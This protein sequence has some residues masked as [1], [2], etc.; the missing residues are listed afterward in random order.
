MPLLIQTVQGD[1]RLGIQAI[2]ELGPLAARLR[3]GLRILLIGRVVGGQRLAIRSGISRELL[4]VKR[5]RVHTVGGSPG[6]LLGIPL[7]AR[8]L[9]D[10]VGVILRCGVLVAVL[11]LRGASGM[12]AEEVPTILS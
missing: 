2:D 1:I 9:D 11:R 8:K 7:I 12:V 6:A 3:V 5:L 4:A 10:V